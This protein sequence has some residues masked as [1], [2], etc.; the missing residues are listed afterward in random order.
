[1][2]GEYNAVCFWPHV[3]WAIC[4]SSGTSEVYFPQSWSQCCHSAPLSWL[5]QSKTCADLMQ[6]HELFPV[7]ELL[8][9][10]C[11][12]LCVCVVDVCWVLVHVTLCCWTWWQ[13]KPVFVLLLSQWSSFTIN[14]SSRKREREK[15]RASVHQTH[16]WSIHSRVTLP[17]IQTK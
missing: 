14:A 1:M 16:D 6:K 3:S 12:H 4:I 2:V 10:L 8:G 9:H 13:G 17:C 15:G 5:F 7:R 11:C